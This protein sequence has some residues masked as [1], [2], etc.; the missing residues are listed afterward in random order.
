VRWEEGQIA[1]AEVKKLAAT[2]FATAGDAYHPAVYFTKFISE[3]TRLDS[4]FPPSS[5]FRCRGK[6]RYQIRSIL[7]GDV[8]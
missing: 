7:T 2:L 3:S 5:S 6:G 8:E 1:T 4:S